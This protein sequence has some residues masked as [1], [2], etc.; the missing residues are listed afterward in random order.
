MREITRPHLAINDELSYG[1]GWVTYEWNGHAVIEH[2]GG[3]QG[4]SA[5]VS[6]IPDRRAGFAFLANSSPSEMT[7]IGSG[8]RLLWP[9]ILGGPARP[10]V[11]PVP[12][13]AG[14]APSTVTPT[15]S[16]LPKLDDLLGRIIAA[17]GGQRNLRRHKTMSVHARKRYENQGVQAD[18]KVLAR[19]P[20]SR[21][22]EETWTAA[23]KQIAK[24]RVFFDGTRGGQETTFGQDSTLTADEIEQARRDF[25]LHP[26]LELRHNYND[27]RVERQAVL[28]GDETYVVRLTPIRGEPVLLYVSCRTSLIVQRETKGETAAFADFR[29]VDG[30]IVPFRTTIHDALGESTIEVGDVQFNAAIPPQAFSGPG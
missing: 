24:I 2:N 14:S 22:E 7:R 3:S 17:Q 12:Q 25:A 10:L 26:V 23:G 8:A 18:L 4:I 16:S 27:V 28:A 6:V 19:A 29:N 9:V 15:P 11:A 1:L 13:P 21:C 30:E 5:I 20:A